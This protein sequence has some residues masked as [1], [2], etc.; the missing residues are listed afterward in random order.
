MLVISTNAAFAQDRTLTQ[1]LF[2][3]V[4]IF[5]GKSDALAMGMSVLVEKNVI[6]KIAKGCFRTDIQN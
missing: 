2:S 4:N 5:D 6:K 1:I 3:N